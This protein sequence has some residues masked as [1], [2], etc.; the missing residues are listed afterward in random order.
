MVLTGCA[1]LPPLLFQDVPA[2]TVYVALLPPSTAVVKDTV[3]EAQA[4]AR[5]AGYTQ[6]LDYPGQVHLPSARGLRAQKAAT[7]SA[8]PLLPGASSVSRAQSGEEQE[9]V[10]PADVDSPGP[11]D[12]SQGLLPPEAGLPVDVPEDG[13]GQ[14]SA[15]V[16][17][18]HIHAM[19]QCMLGPLS[20]KV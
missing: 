20:P 11:S 17:L 9:A 4:A 7:S 1:V 16:Q 5:A 14:V 2:Q 13:A 10:G 8:A 12:G 19:M 3:K 6:L 15:S 18:P